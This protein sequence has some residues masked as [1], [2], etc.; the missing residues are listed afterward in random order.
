MPSIDRAGAVF[1]QAAFGKVVK[2]T[3]KRL[4]G[5]GQQAEQVAHGQVRLTRNEIERAMMRP[6][7]ALRCKLLIKRARQMAVTEIEEF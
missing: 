6:A 7:K 5:D 3:T 2:D 4:L 1:N